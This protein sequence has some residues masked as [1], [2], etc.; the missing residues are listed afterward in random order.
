M[1]NEDA[2]AAQPP[3]FVPTLTEVVKTDAAPEPAQ[4]P[5]AA[6]EAAANPAP[7]VP[8][9]VGAAEHAMATADELLARLGPDLDRLISEAIGRVLHEQMLGFNGR[10]QKAVADVVREAVAKSLVQGDSGARPLGENP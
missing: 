8:P 10:V 3:R 4:V 9:A 6:A 7:A 1:S 2:P 5:P